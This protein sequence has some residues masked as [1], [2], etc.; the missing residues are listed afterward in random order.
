MAQIIKIAKKGM[1][2]AYC[3]NCAN[4]FESAMC[5]DC[6]DGSNYEETIITNA[7][8]IRD[9]ND[10]RLAKFLVNFRNTFGEEYEGETSCLEWLQ[11]EVGNLMVI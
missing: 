8:F 4:F 6:K 10:E 3:E 7:D 11:A 9:M 2:R 5:S 1:E